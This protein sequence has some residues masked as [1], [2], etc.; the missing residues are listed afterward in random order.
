M[1]GARSVLVTVPLEYVPK[2]SWDRVRLR[3]QG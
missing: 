2:R 1:E 3:L